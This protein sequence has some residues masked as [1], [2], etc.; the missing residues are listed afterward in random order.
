MA[1]E[2]NTT[3]VSLNSSSTPAQ[4]FADYTA[5]TTTALPALCAL[6]AA[7]TFD[8]PQVPLIPLAPNCEFQF[9]DVIITPPI[10]IPD[11]YIPFACP[12]VGVSSD[13]IITGNALTGN[14]SLVSDSGGS[15]GG[16]CGVKFTGNLNV[17]ACTEVA[18]TS[19]I[20]FPTGSNSTLTLSA[21][22]CGLSFGGSFDFFPFGGFNTVVWDF[23]NL[24]P[25]AGDGGYGW[26]GGVPGGGG[27]GGAGGGGGGGAGGAACFLEVNTQRPPSSKR[28]TVDDR[29]KVRPSQFETDDG[30]QW[31]SNMSS[32]SEL[33]L[34]APS[35]D[36][37]YVYLQLTTRPDYSISSGTIIQSSEKLRA[38]SGEK[39]NH[40]IATITAAP[41]PQT[42]PAGSV[43]KI[44][45]ISNTCTPPPK[46]FVVDCPFHM[47]DA[48]VIGG[49]TPKVRIRSTSV[50][51][52]Y[53]YGMKDS[54]FYYH[55]FTEGG[56]SGTKFYMYLMSHTLP[57]GALNIEEFGDKA[58]EI[59]G[60]II[61]KTLADNSAALR[62]EQFGT[63]TLGSVPTGYSD[64]GGTY[65]KKI[66]NFCTLQD[67]SSPSYRTP[68]VHNDLCSFALTNASGSTTET[69]KLKVRVNSDKIPTAST[70]PKKQYPVGMSASK[71]FIEFTI[72]AGE[73][74]VGIYLVVYMFENYTI[75]YAEVKL[76]TKD[77][78]PRST[79]HIEY[80]L[81]GEVFVD[82]DGIVTTK[83]ACPKLK[84]DLTP[85]C[86][87][88]ISDGGDSSI[89][90][91]STKVTGIYPKGMKDN[92]KTE[93]SFYLDVEEGWQAIYLKLHLNESGWLDKKNY[94]TAVMEIVRQ[95]DYIGEKGVTAGLRWELLGEVTV[96]RDSDNNLYCSYIRNNCNVPSLPLF[97]SNICP[98]Q[99]Y[100]ASEVDN[101]GKLKLKYAISKGSVNSVDSKDRFPAGMAEDKAYVRDVP[102]GDSWFA[103]YLVLTLH[104]DFTIKNARFEDWNYHVISTDSQIYHLIAEVNVSN[105]D[106]EYGQYISFIQNSCTAPK[107]NY[108][109]NDCPFYILN[110]GD[111]SVRVTSTKVDGVYPLNMEDQT[112]STGAFYLNVTTE[113]PHV[114]L[115][116]NKTLEGTIDVDNFKD[117]AMEVVA[118]K[119][120]MTGEDYSPLLQW[121]YLGTTKQ[122][123]DE[124]GN[125]YTEV[126]NQCGYPVL[127]P[128]PQD[129][130]FKVYDIS[131]PK[132][133]GG[134]DI[135]IRLLGSKLYDGDFKELWVP[136]MSAKIP[137][138]NLEVDYKPW[139]IIYLVLDLD[140]KYNITYADIKQFDTF[141]RSTASRVFHPIA[142]I[143]ISEDSA[144]GEYISWLTNNCETPKLDYNEENCPF[145]LQDDSAGTAAGIRVANTWVYERGTYPKD[146]GEK[147]MYTL[148]IGTSPWYGIY[149]RITLD[150]YG[151]INN[152]TAAPLVVS[153]ED[154]PKT[155]KNDTIFKKWFFL[156]ETT[157]GYSEAGNPFCEW[158]R[159]NCVDITFPIDTGNTTSCPFGVI[160][161]HKGDDWYIKIE[162]GKVG[163]PISVEPDGMVV[164]KD[165]ELPWEDGYVI[166]G[167]LFK[168]NSID[169]DMAWFEIKSEV[170]VNTETTAYYAIAQL[171]TYTDEDNEPAPN[172]VNYCYKPD[173]CVCDLVYKAG[174]Q[175][176]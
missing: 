111:S 28:T 92:T 129:C 160:G 95:D 60:V 20:K 130:A 77:N 86:P 22:K 16:S 78:I 133:N 90:I 106:S 64:A 159:N 120:Y 23:S 110:A 117:Y 63:V 152:D 171:S 93:G 136:G 49:G 3:S 5:V 109:Y 72:P 104:P 4:Y 131:T 144:G 121:E 156:G 138:M 94:S 123:T 166:L 70:D 61:P 118:T 97:S 158:I 69:K 40:L 137:W 161:V 68:Y 48:T 24:F 125:K 99:V 56:V 135:A 75:N 38:T 41:Q 165:Y 19:S 39:H 34:D 124:G 26:S 57:S 42:D 107:D 21:E 173:P 6:P 167:V 52:V 172:I 11:P 58:M 30:D 126:E 37:G 7:L 27:G 44:L 134:L 122:K 88:Y 98:F 29:L 71:P 80:I 35:G 147:T 62:W 53:P 114:Y 25:N 176:E 54:D 155:D 8:L 146:M 100:D 174:S 149:L 108:A 46:N 67:P 17:D 113:K 65:C 168:D 32:G 89:K 15:S 85:D 82:N 154:T 164:D 43:K 10:Y 87:F 103:V 142:E 13:V 14:L 83:S 140:Y 145:Y 143:T 153:A 169:I 79:T 127:Y 151:Y 73:P 148:D 102:A 76:F 74:W 119:Q 170:P 105:D 31:P 91:K 162:Y 81:I 112:V 157:V 18:V 2:I 163:S 150:G 141:Q 51:D 139:T 66:V 84:E 47:T 101:D 175:G 115:K 45:K 50:W 9:P 128:T 59:R 55:S 36:K 33:S 116:I 1:Q 96:S 132:D 12:A